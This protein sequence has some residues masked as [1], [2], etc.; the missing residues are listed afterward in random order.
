MLNLTSEHT[1]SENHLE[2]KFQYTISLSEQI[3][4]KPEEELIDLK[5]EHQDELRNF[6]SVTIQTEV[7]TLTSEHPSSSDHFEGGST[8]KY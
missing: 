5:E 8:I 7:L 2:R 6:S 1:T 3:L 4:E